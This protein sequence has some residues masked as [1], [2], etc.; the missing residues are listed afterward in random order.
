MKNTILVLCLVTSLSIVANLNAQSQHK[1]KAVFQDSKNEFYENM[2][3]EIKQYNAKETQKKNP[4]RVDFTGLDFP[5]DRNLY[6]E[7]WHNE[8]LNQ[9]MTGTCW[10]FSTTSFFESE[11]F[12]LTNRKIKL[13]EMYTV[14]WEYVEKAKRFIAERGN[15]NFAEGS[16]G[17]AV[18]RIWEK[19]GVVPE[20]V[21]NGKQPGQKHHDHSKMYAEMNNYL[22]STKK[23]NCWNEDEAI[24]TIKSIMNHYLGEPPLTISVSGTKMTP[25][26]YFK[27]V[28]KLKMDDYV[29]LMSLMEIPYYKQ[30]MYNVEDNWWKDSSYYNVPLDEWMIYLKSA[31]KN[32]FTMAIGGDVS[33][34]GYDSHVEVGIIPSFDIPS[35]YIDEN[36][37]QFRFSN[38]TTGDDHGIHIVG[39]TEKNGKL[40]LIIKDSG[41]GAQNG[42]NVGY[43][44]Y[45]EDYVKLKMIDFMVH[46]DAVQE[47]LK[48]FK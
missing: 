36:A 40:W 26:E 22:Q 45:H 17:N 9:G 28:V 33:E 31:I 48:K 4:F 25:L 29:D 14:Y 35:D 43:N 38:G 42:K 20:E 16:E 46:K 39:Y 21:Y 30:G 15:S 6:K 1:D 23:N 32:G 18:K 8:P 34:P 13:S 44:F 10:C 47:L 2:Q 19:Y 5:T 3:K 24:A 37:R 41:A 11:I 27:N 12:R 7:Y